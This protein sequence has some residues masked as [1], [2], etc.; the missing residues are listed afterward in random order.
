MSSGKPRSLDELEVVKPSRAMYN[1][2]LL[3]ESSFRKR[4]RSA[5]KILAVIKVASSG[6]HRWHWR[7]V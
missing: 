5:T 1:L 7:Q 6:E 4:G 2:I 3:S